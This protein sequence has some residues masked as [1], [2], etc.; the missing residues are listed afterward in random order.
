MTLAVPKDQLRCR[1]ATEGGRRIYGRFSVQVISSTKC[2][3]FQHGM[4]SDL[5]AHHRRQKYGT[6][7]LSTSPKPV[8]KF[9]YGQPNADLRVRNGQ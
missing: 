5:G 3:R 2:H 9:W 8:S 1:N 4:S 7:S 6:V